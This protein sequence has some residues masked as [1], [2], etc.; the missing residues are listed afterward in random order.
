MQAKTVSRPPI[1]SALAVGAPEVDQEQL[2]RIF[3]ES[4]WSLGRAR[5]GSEARAYI[6]A[7]PV[8]VVISERDLPEGGWR[9]M[10]QDLIERPDSPLLVVATRLADDSLWAEV[11]NMGG[12]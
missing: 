11:L 12:Y 6:D 3:R 1:V 7:N 4:G 9:D 5:G 10:L 2:E 8:R